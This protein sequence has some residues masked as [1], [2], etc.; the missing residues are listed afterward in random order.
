MCVSL[1]VTMYPGLLSAVPALCSD[2]KPYI[3]WGT[4]EQNKANDLTTLTQSRVLTFPTCIGRNRLSDVSLVL[5]D[6]NRDA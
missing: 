4:S 5:G 2:S 6:T 3:R 1:G